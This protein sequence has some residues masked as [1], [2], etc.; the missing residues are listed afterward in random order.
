MDQTS[1]L[2]CSNQSTFFSQVIFPRV[3]RDNCISCHK[4]ENILDLNQSPIGDNFIRFSNA[5]LKKGRS[6]KSMMVTKP[7]GLDGHVGK[8]LFLNAE[9]L[10]LL[11]RLTESIETCKMSNTQG[12][13]RLTPYKRLRKTTFAL[14][15]RLPT[16]QEEQSVMTA[17]GD[18]IETVYDNIIE[19]IMTEDGFFIRLKEIYNDLF[20]T[21]GFAPNAVHPLGTRDKLD[22]STFVD[23]NVFADLT[24]PQRGVGYN[25]KQE[26]IISKGLNI[27]FSHAPLELIAHVVK[28]NRAFT[29][30]LTADYVMVNPFTSTLMGLFP[31]D[32]QFAFDYRKKAK[33]PDPKQYNPY[34]FVPVKVGS[35]Y[36]EYGP[37]AGILTDPAFLGRYPSTNTNVN[38]HRARIVYKV[39]LDTEAESFAD[40][41]ALDLDN[42]YGSFPT[43][44]DKQCKACHDRIDPI[45]GLFKNRGLAGNY[46]VMKWA[47]DIAIANTKLKQMYDLGYYVDG[48]FIAMPRKTLSPL[49]WLA[50]KI[51][52]DTKFARINVKHVFAEYVGHD[53]INDSQF[54]ERLKKRFISSNYD[55]KDLIKAVLKSDYFTAAAVTSSEKINHFSH[56]G[57]ARLITP[58]QIQRK[59]RAVTGYQ[60]Q[61]DL[62][63]Q[64]LNYIEE[65]EGNPESYRMGGETLPILYGGIDSVELKSR[66]TDPTAIINAIQL[67]M[68]LQ[69]SC[70]TVA[71]DFANSDV[72]TRR[73][74]KH[75]S[76]NDIADNG[77]MGK[78]IKQ[79]IQHLHKLILA[80]E[81]SLDDPQLLQT[82]ALFKQTQEQSIGS[83]IDTHCQSGSVKDHR[84]TI[85]AWMA[86]VTYLLIDY[87]FLY[88]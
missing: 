8:D 23:R 2:T 24:H 72:S 45:A 31:A 88:E 46:Q 5:S 76:K 73:Y 65:S 66:L 50:R 86:V 87:Q 52:E 13:V 68:A 41:T 21:Y 7:Q 14:A 34:H 67:R 18:S 11:A 30:I 15:S 1:V 27:G 28:N 61:S 54:E 19:S 55:L 9:Q 80:E 60:F 59:I 25:Q 43:M 3:L 47:S 82:Y 22:L 39:F 70:K 69:A 53:L 75:V 57:S 35:H 37:P 79:D 48:Q 77:K 36:F 4:G 71:A 29:E 44:Q 62:S 12:L 17:D 64:G 63:N 42:V 49:Q 20:L 32:K 56:M 6:G 40:R 74:F 81:L 10:D 33:L 83:Q 84:G 78:R 16:A 51:A 85:Q 38:R 26:D 58:E